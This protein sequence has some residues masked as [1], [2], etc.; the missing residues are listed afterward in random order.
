MSKKTNEENKTSSGK[1]KVALALQGGG[2][3]GAFTWG[4]VEELLLDGRF[5]IEGLTGTSAG[6]MNAVA[7]AQGIIKGGN[8]GGVEA[9]AQFW[10]NVSDYSK[11]KGVSPEGLDKFY[12]NFTMHNSPSFLF[13][14]FLTRVF[15]P[16]QLNPSD[17]NP[18][19]E[20]VQDFFDFDLLHKNPY[21]GVFICATQVAT[22]KIRMFHNKDLSTD[23]LMASAC[24]PFL[25]KSVRIDGEYF[26]DGGYIGNPVL[27]P[28]IDNCSTAD[29]IV[30]QLNPTH[31]AE[32]PTEAT[33]IFDRMNEIT[34]NSTLLREMR[35]IKFITDLIDSGKVV[36]K[37]LKRLHMH[38]I[39]SEDTFSN[40][41]FS[42]K[43]NTTK[44]FL[45]Y[46]RLKGKMTARK[47]IEEN[48]EQVGKAST[49]DMQDYYV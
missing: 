6:A 23:A 10:N 4:V 34:C 32:L 30:V 49:V 14:D 9:L 15:S 29:I 39:N 11:G 5:E 3:H 26:W 28:L 36:D 41:G 47:W 20:V 1:K 24:L 45:E 21:P 19:R 44:E 12:G 7:A 2:A 8:K 48:Y 43:L 40:L 33:A 25:F 31:R 37:S 16:Y 42:S 38:L 18:L 35:A 22:G 27:F 13:F 46:L 17:V